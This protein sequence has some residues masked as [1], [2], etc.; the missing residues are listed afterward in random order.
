MPGNFFILRCPGC[1]SAPEITT[2]S[3]F[4]VETKTPWEYKQFVCPSCLTIESRAR[5]D[6]FE[7]GETCQGCGTALVPWAG[8]GWHDRDPDGVVLGE[9]VEGPCPRCAT[10]IRDA[11]VT[12]VGEWD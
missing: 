6:V 3:G 12:A 7:N 1:A 8:R 11:N 4:H 5:P 9:H 10:T 2:G